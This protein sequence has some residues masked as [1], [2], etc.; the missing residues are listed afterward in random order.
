M[1]EWIVEESVRSVVCPVCAFTFDAIHGDGGDDYTCPACDAINL[2]RQ[3][4]EAQGRLKA[5]K[6]WRQ[7]LEE[8]PKESGAYSQLATW[9]VK[10]LLDRI[11]RGV[12]EE[13]T[14]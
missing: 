1:G 10:R 5:V 11:L 13:A 3:L 4:E 2:E 6:E 9:A 12:K 8:L 7:E 14:R